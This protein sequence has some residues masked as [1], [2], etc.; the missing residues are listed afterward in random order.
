MSTD[1][2]GLSPAQRQEFER[3]L[4]AAGIDV[5]TAAHTSRNPDGFGALSFGQERLWFL[6]RLAPGSSEYHIAAAVRLSGDLD[7]PALHAALG[8]VVARHDALRTTVEVD[9]AT[10]APGQRVH[11]PGPVAFD[12]VDVSG[13]PAAVWR[14]LVTSE[15]ARPFDLTQGP[16]LRAGL[17]R[18]GPREHTLLITIHHIV[19]DAWSLTIIVGELAEL[20]NARRQGRDVALPEPSRS[21]ADFVT[22]QRAAASVA[23]LEP[24]MRY[25]RRQLADLPALDLPADRPPTGT[26]GSAGGQLTFRLPASTGEAVGRLGRAT[27]ATPFMVLLAAFQLLLSDHSGQVDFGVG[28]PVAGRLRREWEGLVG[29][30]VN[31]VVLRADLSGTPT[32]RDLLARVRDCAVA[33]YQHQ[34]APFE[35]LVEELRP[36]RDPDATPLFQVMFA[37][38]SGTHRP[39]ALDG[40]TAVIEPVDTGSSMFDLL[41]TLTEDA[42]GYQ[43]VVTYRSARFGVAT[44]RRLVDHYADLLDRAV[45][46]PDRPVAELTEPV[47][48]ERRRLLTGWHPAEDPAEDPA[49]NP[50]AGAAPAPPALA[51]FHRW[52]DAAPDR[53]ALRWG[54]QELSYR[55][56]DARADRLAAQL[57]RCGVGPDRV[58]AVLLNRDPDL[59]VALW[60]TLKAGGAYLPLDPDHPPARLEAITT[61]AGTSVLVTRESLLSWLPEHPVVWLDRDAAALDGYTGG[62]V[63]T[64][65]L[66]ES[67]AYVR[68]TSGSTGQ[69]KGVAVTVGNQAWFVRAAGRHLGLTPDSRVL[70]RSHAP[71][72]AAEAEVI[73]PLCHGGTVVLVGDDAARDPRAVAAL[74][75]A[76][77]GTLAQATPSL[78]RPACEHGLRAPGSTLLTVGEVLP[79]DLADAMR[80]GCATL[81][82]LYG[83][84][85][86]TV[87]ATVARVGPEKDSAPSIGRAFG[88]TFLAVLNRRMRLVRQ[89]VV[90]E[91]YLG[92]PAIARGYLG[93]PALTAHR[94]VPDPYGSAPGAR[95]YRTGDLVRWRDTGELEFLGRVDHQVKVRGI[96]IEPGEIR[97]ALRTH[98]TVADAAVV[99]RGPA[100]APVLVGY[101]VPAPGTT[102]DTRA[103][104][105]HLRR[106]LPVQWLP[107]ALVVVPDLPLLP[108]GKLDRARLPE[109][110]TPTGSAGRPVDDPAA[111]VLAGLCADLLGVATV[112]PDDDLFALG[113]HS[114]MLIRL[115][116]RVA[117]VFGVDVPLRT[118]FAAPTV[119]GLARAVAAGGRGQ[120]PLPP[121]GPADPD[122]PVP[123]SFG[124]ERL[125]I[126]S[127]LAPDDVAYTIPV[128]IRLTGPLRVDALAAALDELVR[129][130]E[131]LRTTIDL[132][133]GTGLPAPRIAP[134]DRVDL[135]VEETPEADR[136]DRLRAA[137]R[138]PFD[139]A[140]GPLLRATL[141]RHGESSHT[142]LLAVHHVVVDA[143]SMAVLVDE[144]GAAYD[145]LARGAEPPPITAT[146][147][148]ADYAAWQRDWLAGERVAAQLDYWRQRL[149]QLPV[150]H[151]PGDHPRTARDGRP[152]ETRTLVLDAA[153]TAGLRG[154]CRTAGATPFMALL[155]VLQTVL[156]QYSG[157]TD[158]GVGTPVAGR[159]HPG[160]DRVVGFFVNTLVLRADLSG[161]PT[162]RQLLGR[163]RD[164]ALAAFEHQDLP[165]ERLVEE[166]Q[167][168]RALGRTPLFQVSFGMQNAPNRPVALDGLVAVAEPVE[169]GAAKFDLALY[170]REDGDTLAGD[171]TYASDLFDPATI[172]GLLGHYQRVLAA[173]LADPDTSVTG[174]PTPPARPGP[175]PDAGAATEVDTVPARPTG[176]VLERLFTVAMA[177]ALGLETIRADDDFFALGGHSLLAIRLLG[178]LEEALGVGLP[179]GRFFEAPTP[180]ACA[181]RVRELAED[182][183]GLDER[184][185]LV[186]EVAFL[187]EDEVADMLD[188]VRAGQVATDG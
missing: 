55:E 48:A 38:Q 42:D 47:G 123:L 154:L 111:E 40:L 126:L 46:D 115:V 136:P 26:S 173:A 141:L 184:A 8:A 176:T 95:L 156:W 183:E 78:W 76:G 119:T 118:V 153:T 178:Q 187:A 35:R 160:L 44:V 157:Q 138:C 102:V 128:A 61:D 53:P 25:W 113:A 17:L 104:L 163:V 75:G 92:G 96:R 70:A 94:F 134:P 186:L 10:R 132:D 179:L 130:H 144:L 71:F 167:P 108:S 159:G 84:T 39:I 41:F 139:L 109:P 63:A 152:G 64:A 182:P 133:P 164:T 12:L 166:I 58:V 29:F 149:H 107:T 20:Y 4:R 88:G 170:F 143:W 148:Y 185:A 172:D 124:Q 80:A 85:E 60:A 165:F 50:M 180:A 83:P 52:V 31:T 116:A 131:A 57:V 137:A 6:D 74:L 36:E 81:L 24:S 43:G 27:G 1:H 7:V 23:G 121:L 49:E 162:F 99:A 90:G 66:P 28:S 127:R 89:G 59:V 51:E 65:T 93:Q 54:D 145:A 135:R 103:L 106:W 79:R 177:G 33:A 101:V 181:A 62:R 32:F 122:R 91:L 34:D 13:Q 105:D 11:P 97:A 161:A 56:L 175:V 9:P 155:A 22:W 15:A 37:A 158:F 168:A 16:L 14:R 112:A 150:L 146:L 68:Y 2:S 174:L 151:L 86:A 19:V 5:P 77:A 129:R 140:T 117:E 73:A 171:L 69:P 120:V 82:N 147:R 125:W 98:A 188:A 3:R 45:R 72:D 21:Y 18:H 100:D 87:Y 110:P 67:L 114:L 142:L 30:F 169:T